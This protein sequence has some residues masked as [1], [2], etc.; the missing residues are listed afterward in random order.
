MLQFCRIA[1]SK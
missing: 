1:A